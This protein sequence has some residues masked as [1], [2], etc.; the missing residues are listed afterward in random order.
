[1]A[2]ERLDKTSLAGRSAVPIVVGPIRAHSISERRDL[3]DL[4][5]SRESPILGRSAWQRCWAYG[6]A[7]RII[8]PLAA[9]F[10]LSSS[11]HNVEMVDP[12]LE[13]FFF[14]SIDGVPTLRRSFRSCRIGT[15][16]PSACSFLTTLSGSCLLRL[17]VPL[18]LCL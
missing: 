6:V 11:K 15:A 14:A 2:H 16:N 18:G 8:N 7:G 3:R 10:P 17:R 13:T 9:L 1:M 4:R 5:D 12:L